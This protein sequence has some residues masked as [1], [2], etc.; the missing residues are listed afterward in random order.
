MINRASTLRSRFTFNVTTDAVGVKKVSAAAV[1]AKIGKFS[2]VMCHSPRSAYKFHCVLDVNENTIGCVEKV[3]FHH[4][5]VVTYPSWDLERRSNHEQETRLNGVWGLGGI[6]MNTE[7]CM[8]VVILKFFPRHQHKDFGE[9]RCTIS[10]SVLY[11]CISLEIDDK[12][13]QGYFA[14]TP[15]LQQT[16]LSFH[17]F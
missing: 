14:R 1:S 2:M 6:K 5:R 9:G 8:T 4:W 13:L 3:G 16:Q 12:T 7:D 10:C 15:W 11:Q 17:S